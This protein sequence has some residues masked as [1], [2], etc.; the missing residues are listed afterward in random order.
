MEG[1]ADVFVGDE[2]VNSLGPGDFFGELAALDWGAGYGYPRLATVVAAS[3]LRL[4]VFPPGALSSC[5]ASGRRA[6]NP[7]RRSGSALRER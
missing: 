4:L 6:A 5:F 3:P 1:S 2:R 7:L